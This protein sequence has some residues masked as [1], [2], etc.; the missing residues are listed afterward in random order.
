METADPNTNPA[1]AADRINLIIRFLLRLFPGANG[2]ASML[3]LHKGVMKRGSI[4]WTILPSEG[5]PHEV[6]DGGAKDSPAEE[7]WIT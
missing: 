5:T 4:T 6:R 3:R 1:I 7:S 2:R